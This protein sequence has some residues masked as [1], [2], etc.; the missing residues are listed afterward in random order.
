M[1]NL[2]GLDRTIRVVLAVVFF[3]LGASVLIGTWSIVAYVLAVTMLVT[4]A[5]GF[6]PLYK[7]LGISTNKE[8]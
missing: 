1:K 6:C 8:K 4:A 5:I 3:Y 2:G 7:L